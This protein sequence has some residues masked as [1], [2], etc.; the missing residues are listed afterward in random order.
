MI[1]NLPAVK[2]F[3]L[4]TSLGLQS[5]SFQEQSSASSRSLSLVWEKVDMNTRPKLILWTCGSEKH[6]PRCGS[7]SE[8]NTSCSSKK[9]L[10]CE[11]SLK[12]FDLIIVHNVFFKPEPFCQSA[13]PMLAF[14]RKLA[15]E[16][17]ISDKNIHLNVQEPLRTAKLNNAINIL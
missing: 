8:E 3:S 10:F 9:C 13:P 4:W 17:N 16:F 12:T 1:I 2:H 7:R 15:P 14:H 6:Y 5:L 11:I